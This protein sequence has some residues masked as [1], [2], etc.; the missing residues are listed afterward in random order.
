M[1][2]T[3]RLLTALK[4]TLGHNDRIFN[5][6]AKHG[7]SQGIT[8]LTYGGDICD[9]YDLH[10]DEIHDVAA[11]YIDGATLNIDSKLELIIDLVWKS[12]EI[13]CAERQVVLPV[14]STDCERCK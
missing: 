11:E 1:S 2:N 9:F 14:G 10:S 13:A 7:C 12:V 4:K 5:D 3:T 8:G 6:I